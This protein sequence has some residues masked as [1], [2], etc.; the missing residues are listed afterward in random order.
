LDAPVPVCGPFHTWH[1]EQDLFPGLKLLIDK[2]GSLT[3]ETMAITE[4][5]P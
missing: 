1:H 3:P 5:L 2:P 4:A